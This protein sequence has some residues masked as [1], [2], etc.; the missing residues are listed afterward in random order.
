ANGDESSSR[1]LARLR[2]G[3]TVAVVAQQRD[4]LKV[5]Y[6]S[7]A[8][9]TPTPD[10]QLP[11]S[12]SPA[13][14]W[15]RQR[16]DDT[17]FLMPETLAGKQLD[18]ET[19]ADCPDLGS[20]EDGLIVSML[21]GDEYDDEED[22]RFAPPEG[23]IDRTDAER[24]ATRSTEGWDAATTRSPGD[25]GGG[26]AIADDDDRRYIQGQTGGALWISTVD[27]LCAATATY[28]VSALLAVE[29]RR[30]G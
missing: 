23:E 30:Q 11:H 20:K 22:A 25:V 29:A 4:W 27:T 7:K 16:Q 28:G 14:F 12:T 2:H 5:I 17:F 13:D 10:D 19:V 18:M 24:E 26:K 21:L 15:V 6:D 8:V 3:A 1:Q 9:F